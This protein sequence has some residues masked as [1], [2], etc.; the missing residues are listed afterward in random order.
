MTEDMLGIT[1][2]RV[3]KFVKQYADFSDVAEDAVARY[4]AEVR[5]RAFPSAAFVYKPKG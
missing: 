4:A 5:G 3:P 2:E 1:G